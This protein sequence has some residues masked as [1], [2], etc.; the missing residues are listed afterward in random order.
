M[1]EGKRRETLLDL[2][3]IEAS[4]GDGEALGHLA[5]AGSLATDP[6]ERARIALVRG[7]ALFHLAALEECSAVCREAIAE[8]G[9]ADRELRL[10]LEAT[11]LN[12]DALR[13][14]NRK[15][16]TE[17]A[18]EVSAAVTAGERAVLVHVV[19]DLAATGAEPA[20]AVAALGR[21]ALAGGRLLEEVGPSSPIYIYAGTAMAWAGDHDAVLELTTAGLRGGAAVAR[22]SGSATRRPCAPARRCWRGTWRWRRPTPSLSSRNCRAPT[23]WP[24]RRRWHG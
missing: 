1:G 13:G 8:L 21:R 10:A 24:T 4:A 5:E 17:L 18:E 9:E 3:R 2:G 12:A 6:V 7:D 23:R 19:A 22:R 20:D 16:P 11:A 14:V 15:R